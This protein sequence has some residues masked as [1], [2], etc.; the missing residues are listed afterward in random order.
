VTTPYDPD[1][2][3]ADPHAHP[4]HKVYAAINIGIRDRGERWSK[5]ANCG[6]PYQLTEKWS[7]MTTC[8]ARCAD[9]FG[10]YLLGD[11]P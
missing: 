7:D 2:I 3:L 8:S 1:A 4:V 6:D 9:D 5:C 11:T 10:N